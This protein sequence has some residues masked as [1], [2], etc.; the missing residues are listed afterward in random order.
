VTYR[1]R[2]PDLVFKDLCLDANRPDVVGPFWARL[3]GLS[4]E[5]ADDGSGVLRGPGH[6]VWV[7]RVPDPTGGKSRVHLD[8]RLEDPRDV[9]GATVVREAGDDPWRVLAD[10][11]G[12]VLCAFGPREGAPTGAFEVVVDCADAEAAVAWWA[13]RFDVPVHAHE[14][15]PFFWLEDV[16]GSPYTYWVF[17]PVP[18]PKAGKNRVHW[19]VRL[20]GTTLDALLGAGASLVRARDD[21]IR[22]TV[23]ADPEGNEFCVF[24]SD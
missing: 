19:D 16:P 5:S 12:L 15:E 11:D 7:N 13:A 18:E 24:D 6:T 9:P 17:T 23:L 21:E 3:L 20:A 14:S 2:V 22:W 8:V 4:Y 1:P 10:P